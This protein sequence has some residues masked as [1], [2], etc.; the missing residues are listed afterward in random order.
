VIDTS[1]NFFNQINTFNGNTVIRNTCRMDSSTYSICINLPTSSVISKE[2]LIKSN[3]NLDSI[4]WV[5]KLYESNGISGSIINPGY[6]NYLLYGGS[7]YIDSS[8][9]AEFG[10]YKVD[11]NLFYQYK[12]TSVKGFCQFILP[13]DSIE[14]LVG[15]NTNFGPVLLEVENSGMILSQKRLLNVNSR[16]S[17]AT[18]STNGSIA[19]ACVTNNNQF[20]NLIIF[21]YSKGGII[22]WAKELGIESI[23][24]GFFWST[25][26]NS[27]NDG[28][29]IISGTNGVI[30]QLYN[31]L[32]FELIRMDA[33]GDT[34]WSRSQGG[35]NCNEQGV[36]TIETL[37]H[38]FLSLFSTTS[39]P[40]GFSNNSISPVFVKS[41]SLGHTSNQCQQSYYPF[42]LSNYIVQDSAVNFNFISSVFQP[43]S[44][45]ISSRQYL[46]FY[47]L[48]GCSLSSVQDIT[49]KDRIKSFSVFPN[50]ALNSITVKSNLND[51]FI[52]EVQIIDLLGKVFSSF[53]FENKFEALINISNLAKGSYFIKI[54]NGIN[55]EINSFIKE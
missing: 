47:A 21:N 1:G 5:K 55:M 3:N 42:T 18:L 4:Y 8:L 48:D 41:D 38:G 19:I 24:D 9:V 27:C 22:N 39:D 30:N 43:I 26:I 51:L 36:T 13:I 40:F 14:Y 11:S 52:N 20:S 23:E 29:Y 45:T 25:H 17:S 35:N 37:D 46:N 28:G 53:K 15:L 31:N 7:K 12:D 16:F 50:P 33:N 32:D 6:D 49:T 54:N 34:L 2:L 10:I 44:D